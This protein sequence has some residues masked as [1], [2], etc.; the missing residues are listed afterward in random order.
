VKTILLKKVLRQNQ[1]QNG[2]KNQ[3]GSC[4]YSVKTTHPKK[5]Q[6]LKK[7]LTKKLNRKR[8]NPDSDSDKKSGSKKAKHSPTA[9]DRSSS[10]ILVD[11]ITTAESG[12]FDQFSW[13]FPLY[14][15][16]QISK[17]AL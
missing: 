6:S 3:R 7:K 14:T 12:N 5:T 10:V 15:I 16:F 2:H 17:Q 8:L 1:N 4:Q 9:A 13:G 11:T